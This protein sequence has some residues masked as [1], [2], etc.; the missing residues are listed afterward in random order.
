LINNITE[1]YLEEDL[2]WSIADNTPLFSWMRYRIPQMTSIM[3]NLS[4]PTFEL[5][6][7]VVLELGKSVPYTYLKVLHYLKNRKLYV[8][9]KFI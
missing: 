8:F 7:S 9:A 6:M 2:I 4:T 3:I 5:E 1:K